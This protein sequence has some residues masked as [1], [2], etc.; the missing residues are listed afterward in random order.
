VGIHHAILHSGINFAVRGKE[1]EVKAHFVL[2]N[3]SSDIINQYLPGSCDEKQVEGSVLKINMILERLPQIKNT[4]ISPRDAFTGTLHL[5]EGYEHMKTSFQNAKAG[6]WN[7]GTLEHALPGEMYCHSLTDPSILSKEFEQ[8]GYH[9]LT[10]FGLDVP[11]HWFLQDNA[12]VKDKITKNYLHSINHFIEDDIF[13]CLAKDA[14]GNFCLDVKSPLDLEKS[15]GLPKGNIFH[16]DLTWP[17]A[18]SEDEAGTWGV[19]TA[20][21]NVYICGSSAKRGGAVSGI[22]GHNAAM[23]VL[24]RFG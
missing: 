11:Y 23:R 1:T 5:Y 13:D 12:G 16:G 24:G 10:L 8:K 20:Y 22:P 18:G 6:L 7:G 4:K 15:L 2:F 19:E 14:D 3:T 17:F 21:E 9:T